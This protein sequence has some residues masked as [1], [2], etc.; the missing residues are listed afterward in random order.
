MKIIIE[1]QFDCLGDEYL[2]QENN[3]VADIYTHKNE[4]II[5]VDGVLYAIP[6]IAVEAVMNS[7][8]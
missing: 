3:V 4:L 6:K 2:Q 8:E 1:K 5:K 7:K